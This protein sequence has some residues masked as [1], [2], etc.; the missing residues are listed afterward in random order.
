MAGVAI[1]GLD[2]MPTRSGAR[3]VT[4]TL[5]AAASVDLDVLAPSGKVVA[6]VARGRAAVQGVNQ[7]FWSGT[8][9]P[10][11]YLVRATA[12]AGRASIQSMRPV[13]I[14]R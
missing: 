6:T 5:S 12:T 10:G 8:V 4:V 7:L 14:T 13:V 1:T 9:A 11:L 2:V 3:V